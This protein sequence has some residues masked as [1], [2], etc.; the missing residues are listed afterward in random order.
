M[1]QRRELTHYNIYDPL[2]TRFD[3]DPL[4]QKKED[5]TQAMKVGDGST[6]K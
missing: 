6:E 1:H 3:D 4:C 5:N 2:S